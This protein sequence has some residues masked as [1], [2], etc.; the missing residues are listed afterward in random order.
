MSPSATL[1]PIDPVSVPASP[2]P[3]RGSA[4]AIKTVLI[5]LAALLGL[6]I[7]VRLVLD[8]IATWQTRKVLA[9]LKG[10]EGDFQRAH[11]TVLPPGYEITRLK[12]FADK[13]SGLP[14]DRGPVFYVERAYLAVS[15]ADLLRA[16]LT[17]SLRLDRPKLTLWQ[18]G[19]DPKKA[20]PSTPDLSGQLSELPPLR[21]TRVE[22]LDGEL[23]LHPMQGE[24]RPKLWIHDVELTAQNLSTRRSRTGGRPATVSARGIVARSGELTLFVSADPLSSPFSF[25]GEASLRGLRAAELYE[26]LAATADLQASKGTI[27][28]FASFSSRNGTISGGVKP[29]LKNLELRAVDDGFGDRTKAWL[30]DKAVDM[31]SD[32]VPQRNAV[33]TTIPLKGNLLDPDIQLWPAILGVVRNAF[34]VG[35]QSGFA[36]LP[37]PTAEKREGVVEQAREALDKDAGPPQA[38]PTRK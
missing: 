37:P 16:D 32:R 31:A 8:P 25:A 35:L 4:R 33:A 11:V 13:G 36:H 9:N 27:D 34:V 15:L 30:A 10:F 29:V 2:V 38:Q 14:H 1:H 23:L 24:R 18:Q 28:L 5:V 20:K 12:L 21:V 17:A 19:E 3:T 26:F 7:V 22:V 6:A